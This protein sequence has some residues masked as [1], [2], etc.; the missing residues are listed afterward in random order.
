MQSNSTND[1]DLACSGHAHNSQQE[2]KLQMATMTYLPLTVLTALALSWAYNSK[3]LLSPIATGKKNDLGNKRCGGF[4][5]LCELF[6]V[7][8]KGQELKIDILRSHTPTSQCRID[9]GAHV[10]F[11]E[12]TK[13]LEG[14]YKA[15]Y[16]ICS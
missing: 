11:M 4:S 12:V 10:D 14:A 5:K 7:L 8:F 15:L 16:R 1:L 2:V 9:I 6:V 13:G 3:W